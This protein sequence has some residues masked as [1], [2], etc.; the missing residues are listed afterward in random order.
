[1]SSS[2]KDYLKRYGSAAAAPSDPTSKQ[3]KRKKRKPESTIGTTRI[4]DEEVDDWKNVSRNSDD[5][6][7]VAP[8][9][10]LG[11]GDEPAVED[12]EAAPF[13]T[14][15]WAVI[16]EGE[17]QPVTGADT[18]GRRR[19]P[20]PS[21]SPPPNGR[22]TARRSPSPSPSP[23][24]R[25][26]RRRSPSPTPPPSSAH[27]K[28]SGK[29]Q[30]G[31]RSSDDIRAE[32]AAARAEQQAAFASATG[33]DAPTIYR[34]KLGK[35]VDIEAEKAALL[36]A[37]RKKE[38]EEAGKVKWGKGIAQHSEEEARRKK[39]EAMKDAPFTVYADDKE[40][41]KEL[42]DRGRWGDPMAFMTAKK[43]KEVRKRYAGPP[44]PPNRFGIEPGYRWDGVDRSTGFERKWFLERNRNE[45]VRLEAYKWS[46]E[47]M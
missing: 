45:A 27:P 10:V 18:R 14:A 9:V 28:S 35:K 30:G 33:R 44:P 13:T 23:P 22:E 17:G 29:M 36:E 26:R 19:S 8:V 31:L 12:G 4:I 24:P 16:R 47:D 25:K 39:L 7:D 20:S 5:D 42:A 40:R 15:N 34:D 41:N 21:V 32:A 1:M 37:R 46:A 11:N 2:L 3:K 38:E 6:E 43:K